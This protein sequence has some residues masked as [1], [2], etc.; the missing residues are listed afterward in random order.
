LSGLSAYAR[1]ARNNA[2]AAKHAEKPAIPVPKVPA[3]IE[4]AHKNRKTGSE[5]IANE[6]TGRRGSGVIGGGRTG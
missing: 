6:G 4:G 2:I 1:R 3:W 5:G